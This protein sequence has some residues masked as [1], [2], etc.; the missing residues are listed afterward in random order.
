MQTESSNFL[1]EGTEGCGSDC[2]SE[3]LDEGCILLQGR[4]EGLADIEDSYNR[5]LNL[6][7]SYRIRRLTFLSIPNSPV[8]VAQLA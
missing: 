2:G 3:A 6:L 8:Q 7:L 1:Y 5:K 4:I